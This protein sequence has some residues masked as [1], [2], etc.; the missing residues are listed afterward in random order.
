VCCCVAGINPVLLYAAIWREAFYRRVQYMHTRSICG[1][2]WMNYS[3]ISLLL[4]RARR[5]AAG[6]RLADGARVLWRLRGS[7]WRPAGGPRPS[8]PRRDIALP[9]DAFTTPPRDLATA[10]NI[11]RLSATVAATVAADDDVSA[12]PITGVSV[13][14]V[15]WTVATSAVPPPPAAAA[16]SASP[17]SLQ[18]GARN[19]AT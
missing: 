1:F 11:L 18:V 16:R 4:I 7:S 12:W 14:D 6:R 19:D 13:P 10:A 17:A 8:W 3:A 2:A 15:G 5:H 9:D